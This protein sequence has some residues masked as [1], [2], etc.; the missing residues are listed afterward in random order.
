MKVRFTRLGALVRG[1][2]PDGM[3]E[4][5]G[6]IPLRWSSGIAM[7][8]AA[9]ILLIW[10]FITSRQWVNPGILPSPIS[11]ITCI[12]EAWAEYAFARHLLFSIKINVLGYLEA[13]AIALPLGFLIGLSPFWRAFFERHLT[14]MRFLPLSAVV[15]LFITWFGL[16]QAMKIQFLTLGILVYLLPVVVQRVNEVQ[17][18]YDQT[19]VTLGANQWQRIRTVFIPDVLSRVWVD[20]G[21]ITAI[22]WTYIIIAEVVNK[23][24]GGIGALIFTV[25]RASRV[26][27]VFFLLA[28]I[29]LYGV[30]Q[31]KLWKLGDRKFFRHKYA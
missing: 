26:D 8:G 30:A 7:G 2:I 25:A 11:V 1:T 18:V 29:I 24:E 31:D 21:V 3:F 5:R 22:S 14:A 4:L 19:V 15:G 17:K 16:N 13:I 12:P 23:A 20:I 27:M 9:F 10:W 28:V 6:D